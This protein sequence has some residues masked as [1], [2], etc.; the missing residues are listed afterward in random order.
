[1][2]SETSNN[3]D[4]SY[5][6]L[7]P[8]TETMHAITWDGNNATI[9]GTLL[10]IQEWVTRTGQFRLFIEHGAVRVGRYT[11]IDHTDAIEFLQ[12][13]YKDP[14][15]RTITNVCPPTADRIVDYDS[16]VL[17]STTPAYV[18]IAAD[19]ARLKMPS[20]TV[21]ECAV[22]DEDSSLLASLTMV[23]GG[24]RAG[25]TCAITA[26]GSGRTFL[27]LM[28]TRAATADAADR[29]VVMASYIK[30]I[31]KGIEGE[32]TAEKLSDFHEAYDL[33]EAHIQTALRQPEEAKV[34]MITR[35]ALTDVAIRPLYLLDLKASK[36]TTMSAAVELIDAILKTNVRIAELDEINN[37]AAGAARVAEVARVAA[38]EARV[39]QLDALAASGDPRFGRDKK[40]KKGKPGKPGDKLP[41]TPGTVDPPRDADG[42]VTHWIAGMAPCGN[43]KQNH[44][45]RDCPKWIAEQAAKTAEAAKTGAVLESRVFECEGLDDEA[46]SALLS[47]VFVATAEPMVGA[48]PEGPEDLND[49]MIYPRVLL[50]HTNTPIHRATSDAP[51]V[52]ARDSATVHEQ[53][54]FT[55]ETSAAQC[56]CSSRRDDP[57]TPSGGHSAPHCAD[58]DLLT[59]LVVPHEPSPPKRLK[60]S[61]Q[62]TCKEPV[63]GRHINGTIDSGCTGHVTPNP[64][65]LINHRPCADTFRAAAG[66]KHVA[67][68]IG[69]MPVIA[70]D[71][72]GGYHHK[73]ITNVRCVES[74][75]YT[76]FS[77]TQLWAELRVD[78]LFAD[79]RCCRLVDGT[80]WP[81]LRDK[82]LPTLPLVSV[83]GCD[84]YT[85]SRAVTKPL[86]ATKPLVALSNDHG[87]VMP[88]PPGISS[89]QLGHHSVQ[90]TAHVARLPSAQAGELM[91]RRNH[92][93]IR[94]IQ[95]IANTTEDGPRN[96][97]SATAIS[98][99]S[100]A[101]ARIKQAA[102]R[103]TLSTPAPEAGVLHVDLK[104]MVIS[105]EGYRYFMVAVDEFTRYLFIAFLKYKSEAGGQLLAIV[106]KFNATVGTPVDSDGRALPRPRVRTIHS[107]H[108]GKLI[109]HSFRAARNAEGLHH[110]LS[111]PNDHDLN[112]IAERVIR[113]IAESSSAIRIASNASARHWPHIVAYAADWHNALVGSVGSSSSD[114]NITPHQ[115]FTLR[116]PRVMDL[117]TFGCRAFALKPPQHQHKPSLAG[118]GLEGAFFGRSLDS[119]GCYDVL[120]GTGATAKIVRSS[121]VVID[122]EWM[123]LHAIGKQHRP[124]TSLSHAAR[125]PQHPS[126]RPDLP[127]ASAVASPSLDGESLRLGLLFSGPHSRAD[128]LPPHLKSRGWSHIEL[129]GNNELGDGWAH[130]LL[131]DS[132]YAEYLLKATSGHFDAILTAFPCAAP[133]AT[134]RT[135]D[136]PDG[137]RHLDQIDPKL[138]EELRLSNLLLERVVNILIAARSSPKRTTLILEH[139][140]DEFKDHGSI[141]ATSPFKRLIAAADL[142]ANRTFAYCRLGSPYQKYTTVHYTPEAGSVLDE[143]GGPDYQCNHE[144]GKHSQ[145]NDGPGP[146]GDFV[147]TA[148]AAYPTELCSI[149]ARALTIA[150]TRPRRRPRLH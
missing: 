85:I 148:A 97:A 93:G 138:L 59:A 40:F 109:S 80:E 129:L 41:R 46:L 145:Q 66:T 111:P 103:G 34:D 99:A 100:C 91:H 146:R 83:A 122:E 133:S 117:A 39:A 73:L 19:K 60:A 142:A 24:Q 104:E 78:S 22:D 31:Q 106:N 70:R 105:A 87:G 27:K 25:R 130:D 55:H 75:A 134:L 79:S 20:A 82:L 42:R 107:D 36:P 28:I 7:T 6:K 88:T 53:Q 14:I 71:R 43:C 113:T 16:S 121:S 147:S 127:S 114:S 89:R 126:L 94:Y 58:D 68:I 44:L 48:G 128:G 150:P 131:N 9:M 35:I 1:M 95:A 63:G 61:V 56:E 54:V 67:T 119:K 13:E 23:F 135:K 32:I 118:R 72:L 84:A 29:A 69:D 49:F 139:P 4:K 45:H 92:A 26:A 125:Q 140:A 10:K 62:P 11:M 143:L 52:H 116:P 120:V 102:H 51:A 144:L 141:L 64:H 17:G 123:P 5:N 74:F 30:L 2:S 132:T 115:R 137:P 12:K 112:P 33:A 77:V 124:L 76:L 81:Y 38:L 8:V 15:K 149:L 108:E 47:T 3:D 136:F 50:P 110:T 37:G 101:E 21:D 65:W 98:C 96:L 18:K 57:V 90:S 86:I